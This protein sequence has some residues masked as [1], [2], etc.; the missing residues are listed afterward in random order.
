MVSSVAEEIFSFKKGLMS[1]GVYEIMS[2]F[3]DEAVSH[4]VHSE[5]SVEEVKR[6]FEPVY[7]EVGSGNHEKEVEI[8]YK[9]H[10][11][12]KAT[13]KGSLKTGVFSYHNIELGEDL[14]VEEEKCLSLCDVLQFGS[15]ARYPNFKGKLMFDH[16][17][18]EPGRRIKAN[19]C[20][21]CITIPINAR[22]CCN[23]A[24][25]AEHVM[26]DIFEAFGFGLA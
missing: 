4:F 17:S 18:M 12:L 5:V 22:Y 21:I 1:F 26:E 15:G 10:Q 13:S 11:F 9:W 3:P 24:V 23:T 16:N 8:V 25:F 6:C 14:H 2:Q 20:A 7:S 19:T